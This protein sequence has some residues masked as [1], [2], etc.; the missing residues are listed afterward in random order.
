MGFFSKSAFIG[1][2]V[3]VSFVMEAQQV[4]IG[5]IT[6][7][8]DG[9]PVWGASIVIANTTI[10]VVS[11]ELGNYSLIYRGTGS[12]EIAVSHVGYQSVFHKT[13]TPQSF[14]QY[15]IALE[16]NELQEIIIDVPKNYRQ[17]DVDLFWRMIL[18]EKPSKNG[19][20]VLNPEKVYYFLNNNNVL[21][22]SCKESIKI[23][24]HRT[25]Y[26]IRYI[27]QSFEHDYRSNGSVYYGKPFFE[28]L[29]P[30]NNRQKNQWEK[31]RQAVYNISINR[32]LRALYQGQIHE[33]GFILAKKDSTVLDIKSSTS[34]LKEILHADGD[35][36]QVNIDFPLLLICY[37]EP[38]TDELLQGSYWLTGKEA[39]PVIELRPQQITV[40]SDGT[41]TGLLKVQESRNLITGLASILPVEYAAGFSDSDQTTESIMRKEQQNSQITN[42]YALNALGLDLTIESKTGKLHPYIQA[43]QNFS[44]YVPQEKVTL[45]F[46]N[47]SY[48]QGDN[49]WFKC[50][51]TSAQHRLSEL[52]KTLYVELLTPGG[53]IIDKR[54]LKIKDGQCNGEFALNQLP[55]YS[56]FY[57]VRAYT[58]YMLNFGD[59]AIFSRLLPVFEK[60]KTEGNFEEKEMMPYSRW[61]SYPM[62]RERPVREKAVNLRFFPEGGNLI[63]GIASEVA[64]EATDEAGN[65]LNI[66]GIVVDRNNQPLCTFVTQHD[67]KG[68]FTYMPGNEKREAVVDFSGRKYRFDMP[69]GLAQGVAMEVDNLSYPDSID[70][71]LRKSGNMPSAEM[72]GVAVLC[73]GVLQNYF[74]VWIEDGDE[75]S[76]QID[77][78]LLPSGVSQIAL[79]NSNG[80]ILCDR[81]VFISNNDDRIDIKVKTNKQIYKPYEPVEMELSLADRTANPVNATFSLSVRDGAN[82]VENSHTVLTDLLLTSE[83]KG[84][85]RNPSYYFEDDDDT[86]SAALDALLMVQGWRR[87][88]WNR[89]AELEPLDLKFLP[90]QGIDVSG[91]IVSQGL[92][93]TPQPNVDVSVL[94]LQKGK[95][96]EESL[97]DY[98][99]TFTTN[100]EGRFSFTADVEGRWNMIFGVTEKGKPRN[101]LVMLN[102]LFSPKAKQYRFTDMQ[103]SLVEDKDL[104]I[105]NVERSDE[106]DDDIETIF[107]ADKD[108]LAGSGI[109][110][111]V[112]ILDEITVT[113]GRNSREQDI[114]H[115]RATSLAYYDVHAE[116]DDL[117]DSGQYTGDDIHR[118]LLNLN[119][120]FS[121]LPN[122][123]TISVRND[124]YPI[125]S[126]FVDNSKNIT[127]SAEYEHLLYKGKPALFVLDY[128]TVF[129]S[130]QE[131]YKYQQLS[132]RAIKNMYVNEDYNAMAPYIDKNSLCP[133]PC[134]EPLID[135]IAR[136]FGCTVFIETF[137]DGEIPVEEAKGVRK[138]WLEGYS[139]VREFY[140]PLYSELPSAPDYRR[141]IYWNPMVTPDKD[142]IAKIMFYN[143]SSCKYFNI[144][145][146]TVT[147]QGMIGV[148]K[149]KK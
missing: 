32:F 23:I 33:E 85:V 17:R 57:E 138:T 122:G 83:I 52:S 82:M 71:I 132:L 2:L 25:G 20:Q 99:E 127:L 94:L 92:R 68:V 77:K 88:S 117:Y 134:S 133:P 136:I 3:S 149:D 81:L 110:E 15:D 51:V 120:N 76:Y 95:E 143:N 60:P 113:A 65:P 39:L 112:H 124:A 24:N 41:Y 9:T 29:I 70:I 12:F 147:S 108:S 89:M 148:F 119:R 35:I 63:Q 31:N 22:V 47:T 140:S 6:D 79:F 69:A 43:L 38:V 55:F 114:Y 137:P 7:A 16:I 66:T 139:P 87:Y 4:I 10:G 130:E 106:R 100:R 146:E 48:Y 97:A 116:Y 19:I 129:W 84:Y 93:Q 62:K 72:L 101:H 40:Y 61:S 56:G 91:R 8:S 135:I 115:S 50:Y 46:D 123:G 26:S 90:E 18:G 131:Y 103:V 44:R 54:I 86:R 111:R 11:D 1:S 67:G 27:L 30:S 142:G 73:G 37:A 36:V 5:R 126:G 28:E 125:I 75:I 21:K 121:I 98:A 45:H 144:S 74:Y 78:T 59:D 102:R 53:E 96:E 42:E 13:E 64:F 141:T 128:E 107:M 34:I 145:A 104:V 118:I 49:I 109:D 80:E 58:K 14:H 105:N